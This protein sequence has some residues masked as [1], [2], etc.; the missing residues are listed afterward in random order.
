[1]SATP[2]EHSADEAPAAVHDQAAEVA[3]AWKDFRRDIK[4][5]AGFLSIILLT[6]LAFSVNFGPRWN[7]GFELFFA[8]ARAGLIAYFMASLFGHFSL[9]FRTMIFT[10][11]FFAGMV[12][13]SMWGSTVPS[14]GNPIS[15][16]HVNPLLD[17]SGNP[18]PQTVPSHQP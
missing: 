1:M 8:A 9:V 17:S 7:L 18:L 12:F 11:I 16:P 10:A 15:E 13:L 5:F 4:F 6:V 14:I 3:H 2:I